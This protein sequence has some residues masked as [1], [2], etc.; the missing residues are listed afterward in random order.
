M[1]TIGATVFGCALSV[2]LCVGVAGGGVL[3]PA[4]NDIYIQGS[5]LGFG[6]TSPATPIDVLTG[7]THGIRVINN[8]RSS[9]RRFG[10][11]AEVRSAK[12]RGVFGHASA[13]SGVNYGVFGRS[14][15]RNGFGVYGENVSTNGVNYGVMGEAA[16][17]SGVGVGGTALRG[18]GVYGLSRDGAAI[19]G[20]STGAGYAGLFLGGDAAFDGNVGIGELDPQ[21]PLH[22]RG[23]ARI[24]GGQLFVNATDQDVFFAD[25][26]Q[27]FVS[28]NLGFPIYVQRPTGAEL[29]YVDQSGTVF[30]RDFAGLSDER[31]KEN[32]ERIPDALQAVLSMEGVTFD[33]RGDL[34]GAEKG[35]QVGLIAQ[36]VE[37]SVPE[38]VIELENG[39]KGV[40]YANLVA[41]LVEATK[42]Q[43]GE[44][45]SARDEAREA[46]AEN[47][48]LR[49]IVAELVARVEALEEE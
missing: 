42:A 33:W 45:E 9:D 46:R 48:A 11:A 40:R 16:S 10:I 49:E 22:V 12:G 35:R 23:D 39:Y 1:K 4:S 7:D 18:T 32:V 24:Q 8:R 17:N 41:V 20:E 29:F 6:R 26:S 13:T 3:L 19:L 28:S 21:Q 25:Q 44:I 38:A 34:P 14:K 30:A 31:T 2:G 36:D 37:R 27:L 15:S 5:N 43:Q 47:E